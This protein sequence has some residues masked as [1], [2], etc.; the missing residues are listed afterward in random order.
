MRVHW[1]QHVEYEGLG[2][3]AP[4]LAA[5]GH[6]LS[7]TRLYAGERLPR[8]SAMDWL[9]VMG[10]PMSVHDHAVHHWLI[11]EKA[12]L[13]EALDA[14]CRALGICLGAQ[15]LAHSLGAEVGSN[16][17]QEIGW[18]PVT[19]SEDGA[20][21]PWLH[22]FPPACEAYHWHGERY[23]LPVGAVSL[24][25]SAACPQQAFAY[26]ERVLGLQCHLEVGPDDARR[27]WAESSPTPGPWVQDLE[28]QLERPERFAEANR[29]LGIILERFA[30]AG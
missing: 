14:G 30:G 15:L 21:H 17:G 29:R 16:G 25:A 10:G 12:F 19:L 28:A 2:S 9:I 6:T 18:H 23:A 7:A 26:G 8:P 5:R 11:D 27:W 13:R 20:R 24:A 1:L 4:W 3:I 22:D